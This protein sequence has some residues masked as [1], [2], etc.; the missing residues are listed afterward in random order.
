[1]KCKK[2]ST[3]LQRVNTVVSI[4]GY[5]RRPWLLE[6]IGGIATRKF[7]M[8]LHLIKSINKVLKRGDILSMYPEAR[9]SPCGVRSY[10]PES[11]GK[12]VK[13][14]KVPVVAVVHHGN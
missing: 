2:S 10:L 6:L 7:T 11:L 12:I 5:Y 13:M 3:K 1:M 14:N 4:D 8:D 9:Y